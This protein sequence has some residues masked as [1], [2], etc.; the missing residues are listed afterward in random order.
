MTLWF[1][2]SH[3]CVNAVSNSFWDFSSL[4]PSGFHLASCSVKR[5]QNASQE[6]EEVW[7]AV[8]DDRGGEDCLWG[9]KTSGRGGDEEEEGGH[10]ITISKG[11]KINQWSDIIVKCTYTIFQAEM[12]AADPSILP[13]KKYSYSD[14]LFVSPELFTC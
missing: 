12:L 3:V 8:K 6:E 4:T 1:I 10:V 7:E 5:T 9:C 14:H 13:W 11:K 2:C